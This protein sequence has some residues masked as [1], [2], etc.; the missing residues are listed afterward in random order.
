MMSY[1]LGVEDGDREHIPWVHCSLSWS[2][3][4]RVTASNRFLAGTSV[5]LCSFAPKP[6]T[7][8]TL[9]IAHFDRYWREGMGRK[10]LAVVPAGTAGTA[11]LERFHAD[12][13]D[14]PLL[15]VVSWSTRAGREK[16]SKRQ[17][18][19]AGDGRVLLELQRVQQPEG[20]RSW[21]VA[22]DVQQDGGLVVFSPVDP[23]FVLLSCAWDQRARFMSV[24][25]LAALQHNAW[26][27]DIRALTAARVE[28]V[29][30]IQSTGGDEDSLGSLYVKA[31]EPKILKWLR[32]KVRAIHWM[33]HALS[34]LTQWSV[35][36]ARCA[37]AGDARRGGEAQV[38]GGEHGLRSALPGP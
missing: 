30:D 20:T 6:F 4:A 33:V 36:G 18:A 19:V 5:P 32:A 21:F 16:T 38:D 26:L 13:T 3:Y 23:L 27:L 22:N 29:C 25:D 17:L 14:A 31:S 35:G 28:L 34:W 1:A 24:E 37:D 11:Q 2:Q 10:L 8:N 7:T 15:T 12:A 9:A